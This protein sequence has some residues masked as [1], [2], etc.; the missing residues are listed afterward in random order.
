MVQTTLRQGARV[1]KPSNKAQGKDGL[2]LVST[3]MALGVDVTDTSIDLTGER[4]EGTDSSD[5]E[6]SSDGQE[7]EETDVR[8]TQGFSLR[9]TLMTAG[10]AGR[11]DR[12]RPAPRLLHIGQTDPFSETKTSKSIKE[13]Q[14][15]HLYQ[16]TDSDATCREH[17]TGRRPRDRGS[18]NHFQCKGIPGSHIYTPQLGQRLSQK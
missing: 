16:H 14:S 18:G 11:C 2:E 5:N 12:G 17:H 8:R 3:R 6:T 7:Q 9:V 10:F 15:R 1:E 13:K 4:N